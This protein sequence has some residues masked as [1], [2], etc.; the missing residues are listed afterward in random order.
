[1]MTNFPLQVAH[2][3]LLPTSVDLPT[4]FSQLQVRAVAATK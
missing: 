4:G 3:A 1:L 2:T